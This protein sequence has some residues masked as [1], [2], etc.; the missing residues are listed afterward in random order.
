[1]VFKLQSGRVD[2]RF[3]FLALLDLEYG[4]AIWN[5]QLMKKLGP[6]SWRCWL[7][8][9]IQ[10]TLWNAIQDLLKSAEVTFHQKLFKEVLNNETDKSAPNPGLSERVLNFQ[11]SFCSLFFR[12]LPCRAYN[13]TLCLQVCT[14]RSNCLWHTGTCM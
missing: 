1:M 10:G 8:K 14:S 7:F 2:N 6:A 3:L 13:F 11:W 5:S 12:P 4:C 9:C